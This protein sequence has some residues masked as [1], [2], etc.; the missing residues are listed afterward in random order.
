M[1]SP[2]AQNISDWQNDPIIAAPQQPQPGTVDMNAWQSQINSTVDQNLAQQQ[3]AAQNRIAAEIQQ[4]QG[5]R[6]IEGMPQI[7]VGLPEQQAEQYAARNRYLQHQPPPLDQLNP[8]QQQGL[9]Q[10][11]GEAYQQ[12]APLGVD[13]PTMAGQ[14]LMRAAP[15]TGQAMEFLNQLIGG[16]ADPEMQKFYRDWLDK[17]D[18]PAATT[19]AKVTDFGAGLLPI[20]AGF[21]AGGPAGGAAVALGD[22]GSQ[23]HDAAQRALIAQGKDPN[24]PKNLALLKGAVAGALAAGM[25]AI[26]PAGGSAMMQ[27]AKQ[28]ALGSG[29]EAANQYG[30]LLE[31]RKPDL[32]AIL[33]SGA[34]MGAMH[35]AFHPIE[36]ARGVGGAIKSGAEKLGQ[37]PD[38]E[39]YAVRGMNQPKPG[40]IDWTDQKARSE[41]LNNIEG[42]LPKG[43]PNAIHQ[44]SAAEMGPYARGNQSPGRSGEGQGVGGSQQAPPP[45]REGGQIP[46]EQRPPQEQ[47]PGEPPKPTEGERTLYENL[48]GVEPPAPGMVRFYHG[49]SDYDHGPRWLTPNEDY[50]RGYAEKNVNA[51]AKTYYVDVPEDSPL[52]SKMFDD[53]GTDQKSPYNS[54]EAP[55]EIARQL[56]ELPRVQRDQI[57]DV[58]RAGHQEHE[59]QPDQKKLTHEGNVTPPIKAG[60]LITWTDPADK[61]ATLTGKV[62]KATD[63]AFLVD[64]GDGQSQIIR[65]NL[66][67]DHT[68]QEQPAYTGRGPKGYTRA[69]I[70]QKLLDHLQETG[71]TMGMAEQSDLD[72]AASG[73]AF[74]F[75]D[76]LPE[77]VKTF[78]EGRPNLRRFVKVTKPGEPGYDNAGGMDALSQLGEDN[79][80]TQLERRAGNN[81]PKALE[82]AESSQDPQMQFLA[83]FY[84]HVQPGSERRPQTLINPDNYATG[85]EFEIHG[86]KFHIIDTGEG[87][88]ALKDGKDYPIVPVEAIDKIP[89]DK[90]SIKMGKEADLEQEPFKPGEELGFGQGRGRAARP[91]PEEPNQP[92]RAPVKRSNT[93]LK[94]SLYGKRS[95]IGQDVIP[96]ALDAAKGLREAADDVR[97]VFAPQTRGEQAKTAQGVIR[98]MGAT[99]AQRADRAEFALRKASKLFDSRSDDANL[100]YIDNIEN[101]RPQGEPQTETISRLMRE[102]LDGRRE[103][104]RALG[105]GKLEHFIQDYFPHIWTDPEKAAQIFG[106]KRP[107]EGPKSFLKKRTIPTVAEGVKLG[108]EPVSYNPVDLALLKIREMDR[109]ILAQKAIRELELKMLVKFVPAMERAPEGYA[110]IDDRIAKVYG[111][112]TLKVEE[113]VDKTVYEALQTTARNLGIDTNR[114][115]NA[116]RDKLGFSVVGESKVVTQFGTEL[117]VLAHEIG[118]QLDEKFGMFDRFFNNPDDNLRPV[119]KKEMRN[120]ADL[121]ERGKNSRK[122]EEQ[123][124]QIVEAYVHARDRMQEVAPFTSW[125]FEK[126]IY[127]NPEL[128]PLMERPS[129]ALKK[130]NNQLPHHGLLLLGE[131]W[132]PEP[133]ARLLNNYLSPGL[134]SSSGAWRAAMWA[135]NSL[136][137][138]QLGMSGFHIGFTNL[139]AVISKFGLGVEQAAKGDY[140]QAAKS[141]A[142]SPIAFFTK[143]FR[144]HKLMKAWLDPKE[145]TP[146]LA[147]MIDAVTAAG[148]RAQQDPTYQTNLWRNAGRALRSGNIVGAA[149]RSALAVWETPSIAIMKYIVPRQKLG[150]FEDMARYELD[151]MDPGATRDKRRELL[152]K[153]W[154]S[155]DNRLGQIVYDNLFWNKVAKDAA[156]LTTRSV[157]WNLGSLREGLGGLSDTAKFVIDPMRGKKPEFTRRMAYL[158]ALP[159]V[160]AIYGAITQYMYTGKPPEELKD[161][162]F[163]RTGQLDATGHEI[164]LSLPTYMKD[165]IHLSQEPGKTITNKLHPLISMAVDMLRNEDYYGTQIRNPDDPMVKQMIDELKYVGEQF[166]PFSLRG[167]QKEREN[168]NATTTDKLLP[169]LGVNRA[170]QYISLSSAEKLAEDLAAEKFPRGA[171]TREEAD[172]SLEK[173][174][175]LREERMG[176]PEAQSDMRADVE[177]GKLHPTDIK[178]IM[179][180]SKTA[181]L[182]YH[183]K[184]LSAEDA[185]RVWRTATQ[186]ERQEI[187]PLITGKLA[188]S[189]TLTP[190]QRIAFFK[191]LGAANLASAQE[192]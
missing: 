179:K 84:K 109:Y 147:E 132:A 107:M 142:Q 94:E 22:T 29:M 40:V 99:I 159:L 45:A 86:E 65:A 20:A 112:P 183:V 157:G 110:K 160:H 130:L 91:T 187:R 167:M 188:K 134:R 122:R 62:L 56:K 174:K 151:R 158:V 32:E 39:R 18:S 143:T 13:A 61:T 180:R 67:V 163:P 14:K 69:E 58:A 178:A 139:E 72:R 98:E 44:P 21:A 121:T 70:E 30:A 113:H 164:R 175:L 34:L 63:K 77:E 93:A 16:D 25:T 149:W 96:T 140:A 192:K 105:T 189:K 33:L 168:P 176:Q 43:E 118:H 10:Q 36:T 138:A 136:N 31:G 73:D 28:V 137:Q 148:G 19:G 87:W 35:V 4:Q 26:T 46:I 50:A 108:L 185:M 101:G 184:Q 181:P 23:V 165:I 71:G 119:L 154:D 17:Y 76:Q 92:Q 152:G 141:M 155:V 166:V 173:A 59:N 131:K 24:D 150:V 172:R 82:A 60:D 38:L 104:V 1:I 6:Y 2:P 11:F 49:G 97:K 3:L 120:I 156:I 52:L 128:Q 83:A 7:G 117:S 191:E 125:E 78:L 95:F 126:M 41:Q 64:R 114:V 12:S 127:E 146:E 37:I 100:R 124:A 8:A 153:V 57:T 27:I 161:Y 48:P 177:S 53:T 85:T 169:L 111:P 144:G 106:G 47:T 88:R 81:I 68:P 145:M 171:R 129:L 182:I 5:Q 51:G 116:G 66:I 135:G 54:F 79:Y 190:V 42:N 55:E 133:V 15:R 80:F 103:E 186:E 170:P 75:R 102:M 90:G 74:S 123:I 9:N 115:M 89:A 162:Y